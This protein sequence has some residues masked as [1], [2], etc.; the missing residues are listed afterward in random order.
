MTA[1][2]SPRGFAAKGASPLKKDVTCPP[3]PL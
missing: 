2:A 1:Q 3:F